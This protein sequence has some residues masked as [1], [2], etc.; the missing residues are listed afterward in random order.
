ML[1]VTFAGTMRPETD[2]P[3]AAAKR[4]RLKEDRC[5]EEKVNDYVEVKNSDGFTPFAIA[6]VRRDIG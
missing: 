4:A 2:G 3:G 1:A 6:C 5:I